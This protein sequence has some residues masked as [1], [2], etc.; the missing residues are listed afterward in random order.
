MYPA[1]HP[2][3]AIFS[4]DSVEYEGN[5]VNVYTDPNGQRMVTV[6]FLG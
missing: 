2:V 4:E 3:R 5:V 1:G 6:K